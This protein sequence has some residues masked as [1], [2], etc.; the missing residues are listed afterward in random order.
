MAGRYRKD[1]IKKMTKNLIIGAALVG[2]GAY[3]YDQQ[4]QPIFPRN[5]KNQVVAPHA[6][7][8]VE[9]AA[10]D[11]E[12]KAKE[13]G[14]QVRDFG[15]QVKN[16]VGRQAETAEKKTNSVIDSIKDTETYNRWSEKL[17]SY[18][19][20]VKV[21]AEE[22][23]NK[24]LGNWLAIK[25]IDFVNRLGQTRE[26]KLNELA[27]STSS[28]QQEIKKDLGYNNTKWYSW[29][30]GKKEDARAEADRLAN[31]AEAEKNSWLSWGN[32]KADE[33][34]KGARDTKKNVEDEKNKWL[35][36]GS[37]KS[38]EV[39]QK[40]ES[41]QS[42]VKATLEQQQK[43]LSKSLEAGRERAI[44]E[45]YRA[46]KN[47]EDLTKQ[48]GNKA[49]ELTDDAHLTKAKKDVESALSN[50]RQYGANLVDQVAGKK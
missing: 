20:D 44:G 23:D 2:A 19:L 50:L 38:D 40:S 6:S 31:K 46:K 8:Q 32:K 29:W 10:R 42:D 12:A 43:E 36:W 35:S 21:A 41:A 37:A 15:S 26:E 30:S 13:F 33:A 17:D 4:V 22:V 18:T 3:Y 5:Y 28:R 27:S 11:A 47:L 25:Y 39:K 34:E 24:P 48:A 45:Y 1:K 16:S 9:L 7:G 49:S 14:T